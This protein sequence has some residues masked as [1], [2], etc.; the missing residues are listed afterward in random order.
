VLLVVGLAWT[1]I[2]MMRWAKPQ[3][4]LFGLALVPAAVATTLTV[5]WWP[6][7]T[8]QQLIYTMYAS[9][10]AVLVPFALMMQQ[11]VARLVQFVFPRARVLRKRR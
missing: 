4:V 11:Q 9:V 7:C 2:W 8:E 3:P 6:E 10:I 5:L 1:A